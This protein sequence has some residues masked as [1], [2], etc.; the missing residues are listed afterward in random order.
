MF[1]MYALRRAPGPQ[2]NGEGLGKVAGLSRLSLSVAIYAFLLPSNAI[3]CEP[4]GRPPFH[5]D[6][7]IS[8]HAFIRTSN[9]VVH[10][11]KII[12]SAPHDIY[13]VLRCA[14]GSN[15]SIGVEVPCSSPLC[16][17]GFVKDATGQEFRMR[18]EVEGMT[19]NGLTPTFTC[20]NGVAS[21]STKIRLS[22]DAFYFDV[23]IIERFRQK[24]PLRPPAGF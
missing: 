7:L 1:L 15:V 2:K 5:V 20:S 11:C 12:D 3:A 21:S 24:P 23:E 14:N 9:G 18:E 10:E 22:Q 6:G 4:A 19:S 8:R 16:T 17:A 13:W